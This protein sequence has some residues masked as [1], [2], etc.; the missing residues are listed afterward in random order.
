MT[1]RSS[2]SRRK[3][4]ASIG[5]VGVVG[6]VGADRAWL[7]SDPPFGRYT[8]AQTSECSDLLQVAWYETY[9]GRYQESTADSNGTADPGTATLD[10]TTTFTSRPGADAR[11]TYGPVVSFSNVV[12]GDEGTLLVGLYAPPAERDVEAWFR[13]ALLADDENGINEPE[14]KAGDATSSAGELADSIEMNVWYDVGCDED[15]NTW[16]LSEATIAA[17]TL[18]ELDAAYGADGVRLDFARNDPESACLPSSSRRCVGVRWRLP[19]DV[20]NAVQSDSV[21]FGLDF[22]ATA[23]GED[24][25]PFVGGE[26]R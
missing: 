13:P 16:I 20:G 15:P 18:A 12:P 25:T 10:D 24:A 19:D 2:I 5:A 8:Y 4:L 23:C 26:C 7:Q 22:W 1:T 3:V 11:T 14:S 6:G 9:N 21:S 17:G